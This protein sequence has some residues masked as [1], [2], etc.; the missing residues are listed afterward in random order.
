M[1]FISHNI[2]QVIC[3]AELKF[4]NAVVKWPGSVNDAAVWDNCSVKTHMESGTSSVLIGDSGY[5]LREY[6]LLPIITDDLTPD[7]KRYN[8]HFLKGRCVIERAIGVL[9]SRF[10]SLSHKTNG[11]LQFEPE[12]CVNI[13]TA[14]IILH[15]YCRTRNLPSE[16]DIIS[17]SSFDNL[18]PSIDNSGSSIPLMRGKQRRN[19]FIR[20]LSTS[21]Y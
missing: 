2:F 14:C 4:L 12:R 19:E 6:L 21:N 9:K 10:R 5:P 8:K 11:Y 18:T 17:D 20:L 1:T 16:V 3:D 7:E 15:N 13:I